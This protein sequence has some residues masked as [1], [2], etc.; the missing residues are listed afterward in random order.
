MLCISSPRPLTPPLACM[1]VQPISWI[2]ACRYE[3]EFNKGHR[4][5]LKA[6]L[7][8]DETAA[9]AMVLMVASVHLPP[10]NNGTP[11]EQHQQQRQRQLQQPPREQ[12][13]R[14][15]RGGGG[16]GQDAPVVTVS[17]LL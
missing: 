11:R 3:R 17:A 12:G 9:A 6:V 8:H 13:R 14:G 5:L 15:G 1:C 4:P 7:Q 10:P 16:T 2:A